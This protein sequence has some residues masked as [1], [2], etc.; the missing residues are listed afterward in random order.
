MFRK[1]VWGSL[2]DSSLWFSKSLKRFGL[3]IASE[4]AGDGSASL[5]LC[6]RFVTLFEVKRELVTERGKSGAV[7]VCLRDDEEPL[8]EGFPF[9]RGC[10]S[11]PMAELPRGGTKGNGSRRGLRRSEV[12][13]AGSKDLWEVN[14]EKGVSRL[15]RRAVDCQ[16]FDVWRGRRLP[17]ALRRVGNGRIG[18]CGDFGADIFP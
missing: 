17:L 9:T 13:V 10:V 14:L 6:Q 5:L 8:G 18:G 15:F 3:S 11:L 4:D 2:S 7:G 1:F 16:V 12:D